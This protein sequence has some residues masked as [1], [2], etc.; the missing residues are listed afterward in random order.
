MTL[1]PGN[2]DVPT[3][4]CIHLDVTL[5]HCIGFSRQGQETCSSLGPQ[6]EDGLC[7][8]N[9]CNATETC[10]PPVVSTL[11]SSYITALA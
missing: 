7:A 3:T 6:A 9:V 2:R 1:A 8:Q 10:R 5:H 4:C 11:M